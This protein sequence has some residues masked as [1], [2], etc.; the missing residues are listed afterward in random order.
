MSDI[1]QH[2]SV[3]L[4]NWILAVSQAV[5]LTRWERQTFFLKKCFRNINVNVIICVISQFSLSLRMYFKALA[6]SFA[7]IPTNGSI[8][9]CVVHSTPVN[10]PAKGYSFTDA[11]FD[12]GKPESFNFMGSPVGKAPFPGQS[13]LQTRIQDLHVTAGQDLTRQVY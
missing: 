4:W 7:D 6:H 10:N 2:H 11:N 9:F 13:P 5:N 12:L 8:T 1:Y 3:L